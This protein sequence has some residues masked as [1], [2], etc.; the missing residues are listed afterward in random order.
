MKESFDVVF[1]FPVSV[2]GFCK[3]KHAFGILTFQEE[4]EWRTWFYCLGCGKKGNV[5][6]EGYM[7]MEEIEATGEVYNL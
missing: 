7:S 2:C 4:G 5:K 1:P 3:E 6:I